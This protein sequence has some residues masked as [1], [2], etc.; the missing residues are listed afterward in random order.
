[1]KN[2]RVVLLK[3]D[4]I[5]SEIIDEAVEAS[6]K[7]AEKFDFST[8]YEQALQCVRLQN[9]SFCPN[10]SRIIDNYESSSKPNFS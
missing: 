10:I 4:G 8:G 3:G 9:K 5:G 1:M 7:A 6:D 2:C